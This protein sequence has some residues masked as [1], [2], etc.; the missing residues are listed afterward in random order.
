MVKRSSWMSG[1]GRFT[2]SSDSLGSSYLRC[3]HPPRHT[4]TYTHTSQE[5]LS[6]ELDAV[7][8]LDGELCA[9]G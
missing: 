3:T 7:W 1:S 4:Y 6:A 5:Q 9:T 8:A 2:S